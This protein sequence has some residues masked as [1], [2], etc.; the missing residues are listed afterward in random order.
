MNRVS[1]GLRLAALCCTVFS[2][3]CLDLSLPPPPGP[4][5]PGT[6]SGRV[7]VAQPG[8]PEKLARS[9]AQ[10][11]VLGTGLKV[12]TDTGGFF[13]IEGISS[14]AGQVLFS[15]DADGDGHPE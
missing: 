7:V 4:P 1:I 9:G 6:I 15:F 13:R 5:R 10:V 3:G 14:D 11:E 2:F 12:T 8:R